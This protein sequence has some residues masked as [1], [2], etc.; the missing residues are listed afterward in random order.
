LIDGRQGQV[1][2]G[3]LEPGPGVETEL[4][5]GEGEA[6]EDGESLAAVVG[7]EEEQVLAASILMPITKYA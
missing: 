3:V 5:A 1:G 7:V 2:E 6:G 4:L